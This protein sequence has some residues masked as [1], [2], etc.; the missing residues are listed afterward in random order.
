MPFDPQFNDV[1]K[2]G[3]KRAVEDAGMLA[4]RV[5][6]QIFHNERM[7]ERIYN[8]IDACDFVIADMSGKNPNVFYEVGYA[9]AKGKRCILLTN[10]ATDIPFDLKHHRHIVYKNISELQ[11]ALKR[12]IGSI[13][14]EIGSPIEANEN[15]ITGLLVKSKYSADANVTFSYDITN[16]SHQVSPDIDHVYFYTGKN[17]YISQDG[18]PCPSTKSDIEGFDLRHQVTSP[19]VRIQKGGWA[20]LTMN[21]EKTLAW[22]L[23]GEKLEDKYPLKGVVLLRF[24]TA[25]GDHRFKFSVSLEVDE[26]P[27]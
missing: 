16:P 11:I 4:E 19:A 7:L 8:Q 15:S 23:S 20:R 3:I 22:A 21:G 10:D 24:L 18:R 27:F 1:Y 12:D 17:W 14:T 2:L 9:H 13:E 5:D 26:I 25:R 6:E